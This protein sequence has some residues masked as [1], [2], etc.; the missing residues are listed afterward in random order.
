MTKIRRVIKYDEASGECREYHELEVDP[1]VAGAGNPNKVKIELSPFN[2]RE[3]VKKLHESGL[4]KIPC[5]E[6]TRAKKDY[7]H[8]ESVRDEMKVGVHYLLGYNRYGDFLSFDSDGKNI[9]PV[10]CKAA[11]KR[12]PIWTEKQRDKKSRKRREFISM[13]Y[14]DRVVLHSSGEVSYLGRAYVDP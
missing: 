8:N 9:M 5:I 6:T 3:V 13:F 2:L 4:D 10:R 11:L 14:M 12:M 7:F 1:R